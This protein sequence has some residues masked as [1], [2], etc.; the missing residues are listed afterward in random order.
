MAVAV[1]R[2]T[3]ADAEIIARFAMKLVEQHRAYDPIRFAGLGSLDGMA[4]FYGS[5]TE[6]KNAAVFV[7]EIDG[8]VVGF[9]YIGYEARNYVELSEFSARLHDIYVDESSR[10][11]RAGK[12]LIDAAADAALE[13]GASKLMLSVAAQNSE[14]Q[15]F[16]NGSGFRTTMLEMMLTVDQND[17]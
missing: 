2:A 12:S 10:G 3:K 14:A 17:R 4:N 15:T 9:A 5:Q 11:H 8:K 13:F 16:F 7:A 1:R 6:A